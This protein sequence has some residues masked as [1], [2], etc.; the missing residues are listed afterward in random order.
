MHPRRWL[1]PC[2]TFVCALLQPVATFGQQPV[3]RRDLADNISALSIRAEQLLPY[4]QDEIVSQV[5]R[6]VQWICVSLSSVIALYSFLRVWRESE[7][8]GKE[9]LFWCVRL[10]V[11]LLLLFTGPYLVGQLAAIGKTI[12]EGNE[13]T[14]PRGRSLLYDF[15]LA[16]QESFDTSYKKFADGHFTVKVNGEVMELEGSPPNTSTGGV[17][18]IV[19]DAESTVKDIDRK[20]DITSYSLPTLFSIFNVMRTIV[21]GGDLWLIFL[22]ALLM[23]TAKMLAPFAVVTAI[24]KQLAHRFTWPFVY[25]CIVLCVFWPSVSYFIRGLAFLFGNMAMAVGDGD[26]LYVWD[27]AT[28][29]AV[30]S[31]LQHPAY[32]IAIGAFGMLLIGFCV[33]I[34]PII[35][36]WLVAGKFYEGVSMIASSVTGELVSTGVEA[37][38]QTKSERLRQAASEL[39]ADAG[40]RADVTRASGE[41]RAATLSTKARQTMAEAGVRGAQTTQ[42]SQIY[43]ARTNQVM[44]AEAGKLFGVSSAGAAAALSKNETRVRT[45][46]SISDVKV[47][48][49]QQE[50]N[51]KTSQDADTKRWTGDK[52]IMAT[53]YAG[54]MIGGREGTK[55]GR[56]I[57]GEVVRVAGSGVGLHQQYGSIQQRAVEQQAALKDAATGQ[58]ANREQAATGHYTNQDVYLN[59]MTQTH[60]E[61]AAGQTAAANAAAGQ[62][63]GGVNRGAA[64]QMG[65]INRGTALEM[66]GNQ[67]RLDA[68]VSAAGINRGAAIEA[69]KLNAL[70]NMMSTVGRGI[71]RD[72]ERVMSQR[73]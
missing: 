63:A 51:I 12:A 28:M 5:I 57:A 17:L 23:I 47:G 32:T 27:F 7:G 30:R 55:S 6:Y 65:G 48:Q 13:M 56:G 73:Y 36:G 45:D 14:G 71:A 35:T 26:P 24:D 11:C 58:V 38:T 59:Q 29:H 37:Y 42:L 66:Q 49:T 39:Q 1:I 44:S 22:A 18:G 62:A 43:A 15:Y 34:S 46:Q 25:G 4:L 8:A 2:T 41:Y 67:A 64:I 69:A 50:R 21:D 70:S 33:W 60:A 16:Q 31:P 40:Y 53:D 72:I 68:Q 9:T 54:N 3:P 61:Y 19:Y 10:G 52:I 20:L